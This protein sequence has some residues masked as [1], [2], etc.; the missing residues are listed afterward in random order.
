MEEEEVERL[1]ENREVCCKTMS[2][3][4]QPPEHTH[5][6]KSQPYDIPT[7]R[8]VI[9]QSSTPKGRATKSYLNQ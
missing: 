2:S 5:A 7:W 4:P 9:S 6:M 8:W 1:K 3:P